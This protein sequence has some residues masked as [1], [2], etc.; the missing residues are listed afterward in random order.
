MGGEGG[1]RVNIYKRVCEAGRGR[2]LPVL[3]ADASNAHTRKMVIS[4]KMPRVMN[5]KSQCRLRI[6]LLHL[7]RWTVGSAKAIGMVG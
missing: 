3:L 7:G 2:P 5:W 1:R 4:W 6:V